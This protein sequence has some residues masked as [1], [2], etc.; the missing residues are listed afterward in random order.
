MKKR[1]NQLLLLLLLLVLGTFIGKPNVVSAGELKANKTNKLVLTNSRYGEG[2]VSGVVSEG[3][4]KTKT[5]TVSVPK[6]SLYINL[7]DYNTSFKIDIIDSTNKVLKTFKSSRSEGVEIVDGVFGLEKGKYKIKVTSQTKEKLTG[8][9][10]LT[11]LRGSK[12]RTIVPNF[13]YSTIAKAKTTYKQSFTINLSSDYM[14]FVRVDVLDIK[15]RSV[16]L[17]G[18]KI[19]DSNGKV[20][21]TQKAKT[22]KSMED[23]KSWV[24]KLEE[25]DYTLEIETNKS[26]LLDTYILDSYIGY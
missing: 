19:K 11:M 20:V 23:M 17:Q 8:Y 18:V 9:I 15:D 16:Y 7:Q 25:G 24:V 12:N 1:V 4:V 22:L 5:F 10:H 6:G 21:A 3:E 2:T 13:S 14:I 26:G